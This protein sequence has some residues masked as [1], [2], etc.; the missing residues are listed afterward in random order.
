MTYSTAFPEYP[1]ADMPEIPAGFEDTSWNNDTCPSYS[2]S[3]FQIWIDYIDPER[4]EWQGEYPR[5]NVQ[6][7]KDGIEITGDGGLMTDS[8]DEVLNYL[9]VRA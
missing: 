1:A 5:F 8:W 9:A 6:P 2:N 7:M 4:R 3:H